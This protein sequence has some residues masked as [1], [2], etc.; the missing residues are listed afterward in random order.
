MRVSSVAYTYNVALRHVSLNVSIV[1][2]QGQR[3]GEFGGRPT[4][5]AC[6]ICLRIRVVNRPT[7][8]S[9]LIAGHPIAWP[10]K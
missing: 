5:H 2:I 7:L 3:G 9:V 4:Y 10:L 8:L 6:V 1:D